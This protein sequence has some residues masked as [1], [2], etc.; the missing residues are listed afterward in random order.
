MDFLVRILPT[1]LVLIA[2][3]AG[4]LGVP[5]WLVVP[6]L[7]A[8][9]GV[10]AWAVA[11]YRTKEMEEPHP[12]RDVSLVMRVRGACSDAGF[13]D[14]QVAVVA[15]GGGPYLR[16]RGRRVAI[17]PDAADILTD[18]ELTA[19]VLHQRLA[20]P[21]YMWRSMLEPLW[22]WGALGLAVT[23]A[24][25]VLMEPWVLFPGLVLYVLSNT[26]L[27]K[28]GAPTAPRLLRTHFHAFL[29]GGGNAP[30]YL[31]GF[32]KLNLA[33][34]PPKWDRVARAR[35]SAACWGNLRLL[36]AEAGIPEAALKE[37]VEQA[38]R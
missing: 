34:L 24:G 10:Y 5:G 1:V 29:D 2:L 19:H 14:A 31:T 17:S 9:I 18:E 25:A 20:P 22:P 16:V 35:M 23:A 32:A 6:L 37:M 11:S 13:S 3:V 30:A 27:R 8:L 28:A 21:F 12:E 15:G 7:G 4:P 36:A 26:V 33:L 38:M